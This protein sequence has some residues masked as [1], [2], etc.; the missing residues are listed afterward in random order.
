MKCLN[1]LRRQT[2][3]PEKPLATTGE[4][5]VT[6]VLQSHSPRTFDELTAATEIIAD[7][8]RQVLRRLELSGRITISDYSGSRP[9]EYWIRHK[10]T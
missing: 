10:A 1:W 8:L 3:R 6:F 7:D 4:Q 5:S 9:T 2:G